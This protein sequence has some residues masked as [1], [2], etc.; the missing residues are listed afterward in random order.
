MP[1]CTGEI[2]STISEQSAPEQHGTGGKEGQQRECRDR[3]RVRPAWSTRLSESGVQPDRVSVLASETVERLPAT[4]SDG[5]AGARARWL[6]RT[7]VK[8]RQVGGLPFVTMVQPAGFW[9][10]HDAAG[11]DRVGRAGLGCVRARA[12]GEFGNRGSAPDRSEGRAEGVA[13]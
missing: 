8:Q 11:A 12:Q 1:S 13:R 7:S 6:S 9:S 5:P 2:A 10:R 4:P 3:R